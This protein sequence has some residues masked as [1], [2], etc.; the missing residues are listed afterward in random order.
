MRILFYYFAFTFSSFANGLVQLNDF[1][2]F[3]VFSGDSS[4]TTKDDSSSPPITLDVAFPFA[5]YQENK[6]FVNT[7]GDITFQKNF[8]NYTPVCRSL[9]VDLRMIIPFWTDI[10]MRKGG[11]VRFPFKSSSF[12]ISFSHFFIGLLS[13]NQ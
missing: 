13:T 3:G 7:N 4:L 10:D 12:S 8:T 6:L 11:N 9:G 5:D 2:P 1:F